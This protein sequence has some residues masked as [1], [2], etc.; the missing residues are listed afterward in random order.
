MT[1]AA[2]VGEEPLQLGRLVSRPVPDDVVAAMAVAQ[3]VVGTGHRIAEELLAGRQAERHH[4]KQLAMNRRRKRSLR[5]QRPP[6][7]VAGIER[8][9]LG[10]ALLADGRADSVGADE[11]IGARS[12][13]VAEAGDDAARVLVESVDALATMVA[14]GGKY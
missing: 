2:L 10:R 13:A 12:L 8:R 14:V 9:E 11:Q 1:A 5:E 4:A 3:V 7:D 6:S